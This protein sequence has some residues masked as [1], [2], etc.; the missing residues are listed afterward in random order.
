MMED[1]QLQQAGQEAAQVL[2]RVSASLRDGVQA[3]MEAQDSPTDVDAAAELLAVMTERVRFTRTALTHDVNAEPK[4]HWLP[5][6]RKE[7]YYTGTVLPML[8]ASDGFAHLH[9]L[10]ELCGLEG[11]EVRSGL[12]GDQEL[13]FYTEYGFAESVFTDEDKAKWPELHDADT[14]DVVIAGDD[15]LLAIEAKMF[16]NP[17]HASLERQMSRQRVLVDYWADT[18]SLQPDR[19]AHVLLLPAALAHETAPKSPVVTW[20]QLRDEFRSVA[21]RY[22]VRELDK[23]LGSYSTL[24]S[25]AATANDEARLTGEEIVAGFASGDFEFGYV[26]RVGG[27]AGKAFAADVQDGGWRSRVYQVRQTAPEG[28]NAHWMSIEDFL[29]STARENSDRGGDDDGA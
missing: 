27:A 26:G 4:Q 15:W 7:R 21:P 19:V 1:D 3:F 8:C 12:D 5:V 6:N 25:R 14:P 24:R 9:R 23:A 13:V 2:D 10:L 16:H 11:V 20:E 22:W 17:S 29:M 18:L 28:R